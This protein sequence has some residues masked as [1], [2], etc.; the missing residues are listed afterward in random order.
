MI[1]LTVCQSLLNHTGIAV[2]FWQSRMGLNNDDFLPFAT[3]LH[4]GEML[5]IV[6]WILSSV[7][8]TAILFTSPSN[9]LQQ[10]G[11]D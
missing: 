1:L 10:M 11:T 8:A 6:S 3:R 7:N 9:I 4:L 2:W 5:G